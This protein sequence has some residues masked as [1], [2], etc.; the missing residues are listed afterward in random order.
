MADPKG[1]IL[2]AGNLDINCSCRKNGKWPNA[3]IFSK[4]VAEAIIQKY[5][6]RLPVAIFRPSLDE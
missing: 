5:N 1:L 6:G 2:I 3:Y 4:A